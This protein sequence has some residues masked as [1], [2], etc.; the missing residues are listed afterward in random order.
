MPATVTPIRPYNPEHPTRARIDALRIEAEMLRNETATI[1]YRRNVLCA[2]AFA[3]GLILGAAGASFAAP[4]PP[5]GEA[6]VA[7]AAEGDRYAALVVPGW[8]ANP[9]DLT[10]EQM[11]AFFAADGAGDP[12]AAEAVKAYEEAVRRGC[13]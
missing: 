11:D 9:R 10:D 3:L 6:C 13:W 1:A 5:A 7:L 12:N 8:P 4:V 2:T